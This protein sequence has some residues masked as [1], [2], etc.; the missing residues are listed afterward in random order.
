VKVT[1]NNA[2]KL[3][4]NIHIA[5]AL[6]DHLTSNERQYSVFALPISYFAQA[7]DRD[8][9]VGMTIAVAITFA[10]A[11]LCGLTLIFI[12]LREEL[13]RDLPRGEL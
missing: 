9:E 11:M 10:A 2:A 6:F 12:T 8:R 4:G 13:K 1:N 3:A 5:C 7:R